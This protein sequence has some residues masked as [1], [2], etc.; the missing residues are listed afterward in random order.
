M[1]M[2]KNNKCYINILKWQSFWEKEKMVKRQLLWDEESIID[3][4]LNNFFS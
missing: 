2:E 1:L 3:L 4:P